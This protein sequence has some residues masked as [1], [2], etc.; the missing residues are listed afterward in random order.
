MSKDTTETPKE[1]T[2]EEL[3]KYQSEMDAFYDKQL[4]FLQ[5]QLTYETHLADIEEAR[6][7]RYTM[8]MRQAQLMTGNGAGPNGPS[9][10]P[11]SEKK[12]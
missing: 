1:P 5:K 6:A 12:N 4:P 9:E 3:A 11:V 10:K 8:I 7:R 2:P